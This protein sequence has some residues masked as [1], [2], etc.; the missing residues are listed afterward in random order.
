M[1]DKV[2]AIIQKA[3]QERKRAQ[4]DRALK[5]LEAGIAA[6]PEELDLYLEAIDTA[7]EGGELLPATNL[8]KT[9]QDKFARE[10]DRVQQFVLEKLQTVHDPSLA[11]CAV[12]H[13]VKRRDLEGALDLLASVPDHTIRELLNR[14]RAKAQ[15]LKSA[16]GGGYA[17]RGETVVNELTNAILSIRLGNLKDAMATFVTVVEDKSVEHKSVESF[18]AALAGKNPK[19]GRIRYARGCAMRVGG[20]EIE[21]IQLFVEAARLEPACAVNC[22]EQLQAMLE[23]SNH[24]GKVRRALAE[25]QLLKGDLDDAAQTLREYLKDHTD[26]AREVI[27]LLRPYIEPSDQL[28]ACTWLAL[29]QALSLE[30][31]SLLLELMRPLQAKGHGVELFQWL[32]EHELPLPPPDIAIFHA[33]LAIEAKEYERAVDM[34]DDVCTASPQDIPAV[35]ALIDKHRNDDHAIDVLHMKYSPREVVR[36][37]SSAS[38]E[39]AEFQ[40]F[41]PNE[42][43]LET[44]SGVV[45]PPS[46]PGK[47]IPKPRFNSSPF[48]SGAKQTARDDTPMIERT[49]LSLDD[50]APATRAEEEPARAAAPSSSPFGEIEI[51]EEHVTNVAQKLYEAGAAVFFHIDD[52]AS[53]ESAVAE[54]APGDAPAATAEAPGATPAPAAAPAAKETFE[55]RYARFSKG[56]LSNAAVLELLAEAVEDGRADELHELLCFEPETGEEH[57]ARYYYQAEYHLLSNRPLQALEIL[58]RLDTPDLETAHKQRVWYKIAVAQRMTHNYEGAGE[59]LDRLVEQFPGRE[60]FARLKRRNQEQFI[61]TQS[62]AVMTLEKTSSLD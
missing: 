34:L 43:K 58:A 22:I 26:N 53:A 24:P 54:D 21:A 49:E 7:I 47:E 30:Q 28:N 3:S 23:G 13:A 60:D 11:R 42:F 2:T 39:D 9:V 56:E 29:E 33:S 16:A 46:S 61:E 6:H 50:D 4:F 59:T 40:N 51:I 52:E 41:E 45:T 57:F 20:S 36:R 32:E 14:T 5:R 35:V 8:L 19:A 25:T 48:S 31:S 55:Q 17:L 44:S 27:M 12:E 37:K 18:L 1:N 15:S 10:R 62:L 38:N